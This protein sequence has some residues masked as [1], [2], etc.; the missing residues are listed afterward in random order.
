MGKPGAIVLDLDHTMVG[1]VTPL[2]RRYTVLDAVRR[3]GLSGPCPDA[4]L[5][6]TLSTTPLLR[7]GLADFL[8]RSTEAG[9]KLYVFTA[10]ER[11]WAT[12]LVRAL[13]R[14][15]GARF[16]KPLFAR[17]DCHASAGL[18]AKS[19]TRV[20]ARRLGASPLV[21]DN[22]AVWEDLG[23]HGARFVQCPTYRYAPFV[24][25]LE[26][27][28]PATLRDARVSSLV[29]QLASQ[30]ECYDPHRYRDAVK[31]A[32]ARHRF[33]AADALKTL[34]QNQAQVQARDAFFPGLR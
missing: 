12:A 2:L 9:K 18:V 29:A 26:G 16:A 4:A 5:V 33:L 24:D 7:P 34:R 32:C 14:A 11:G 6:A 19:L 1:D 17:D 31:S 22:S 13:Q 10:S 27:L 3:W 20:G 30:G 15:T 21:I 8:R 25:A 28:P 23:E